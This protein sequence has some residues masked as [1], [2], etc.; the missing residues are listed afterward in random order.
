MGTF[1][2]DNTFGLTPLWNLNCFA[3]VIPDEMS[4]YY[5]PF[6]EF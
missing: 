1:L 3:K 5:F 6:M 2:C 4:G